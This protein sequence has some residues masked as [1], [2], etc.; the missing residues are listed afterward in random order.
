MKKIEEDMTEEQKANER[1]I[2]RQQMEAIFKLMEDQE[3][4]FG[5]GTM[6]DM[7]EQMKLYR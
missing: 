6:D 1:E 4:K 3:E 2:Q 7:Q 5:V